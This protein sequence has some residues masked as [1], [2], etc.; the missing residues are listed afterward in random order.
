MATT[1]KKGVQVRVNS[2]LA[3]RLTLLR[4]LG[5]R[6]QYLASDLESALL[7][8]CKRHE[9]RL[10]LNDDSW[11]EAKACS[12]CNTGV[13][14][15]RVSNK[16]NQGFLGCSNFPKCRHSESLTRPPKQGRK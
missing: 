2:S 5:K 16:G 15:P 11:R 1:T 14:L 10:K 7:D 13:L 3:R 9:E 8:V 12:G 4:Q 6:T